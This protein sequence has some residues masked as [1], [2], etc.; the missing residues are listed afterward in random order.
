MSPHPQRPTGIT[1]PD[2]V[3]PAGPPPVPGLAER[4]AA[5]VDALVTGGPVPSGFDPGQVEATR[6]ALLRK[7]AAEA[8]KAWP[9]LAASLGEHWVLV[10]SA[11]RAGT[12]PTSGLRD[13][14]E[15]ARTLCENRTLSRS[16]SAELDAR[17]TVL[18]FDGVGPP[19][20]RRFPG[21]R[22]IVGGLLRRS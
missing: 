12:E 6:R 13:G 2:L 14:W 22:R 10:F 8:A 21:A 20:A 18:R 7:R 3:G 17:E 9:V 4:Q 11:H 15:L 1:R 16:A 19:M 5:L